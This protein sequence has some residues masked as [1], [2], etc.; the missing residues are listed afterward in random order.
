[1]SGTPTSAGILSVVFTATSAEGL[2]G[3]RTLSL[4]IAN[5]VAMADGPGVYRGVFIDEA[6][7]STLGHQF[8]ADPVTATQSGARLF[9]NAA[10]GIVGAF[11]AIDATGQL[12]LVGFD[13]G[14]GGIAPP[15]AGMAF[16]GSI[17]GRHLHRGAS[18][19]SV[20]NADHFVYELDRQ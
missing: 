8:P 16:D 6:P 19:P 5:A 7:G 14:S 12:T 10:G 15:P 17:I 13:D 1:M 11:A 9:L 3:T 4:T 20:P 2:Q 18:F